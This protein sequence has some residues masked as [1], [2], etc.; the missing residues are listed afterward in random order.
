MA[1]GRRGRPP[2]KPATASPESRA[3]STPGSGP[4]CSEF[5]ALD[6]VSKR[7]DGP[8][9]Q[10]AVALKSADESN[11]AAQTSPARPIPGPSSYAAMVDPDDGT[12]LAFV[13]VT[14]V[15]GSKCAKLETSD[16]EDEILYWQSA[17]L[18]SVLGAN[19]PLAVM[20]RYF[21]KIWANYTIDK[22]LYVRKGVF[23]VRFA[24]LQ[25]KLAVVTKGC[26]H[27]DRKPLLVKGWNPDMDLQT[28]T[29]TSLPL[30]IQLP[31]LDIKYWGTRSLS[32]IGSMLGI[33][34]KTD[35]FTKERSYL[36]YARLLIDMP[37]SGPFPAYVEFFNDAEVLIRQEVVYEWFPTKC[38]HC[39]MFG[40][41]GD[42]C[43]HKVT[44]RREWGPVTAIGSANAP[45]EPHPAR[46]V[47]ALPST[48]V[49]HFT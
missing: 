3:V 27:F 40:H 29:I 41:T 25:D 34:L 42:V 24:N 9:Q 43:R 8:S 22:V 48:S 45:T 5:P 12:D 7:A 15:N 38:D 49:H 36:H 4:H 18:C 23:M 30:W 6:V 47:A 28:E 10:V 13:P 1:R 21:Q 26:Y 44:A 32:K 2:A 31:N 39:S 35:K 17:V 37:I 14:S 20:Q 46:S 19:P 11:A 16:V 33:P